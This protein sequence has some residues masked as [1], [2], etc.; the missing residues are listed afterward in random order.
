MTILRCVSEVTLLIVSVVP[1]ISRQ[2][3]TDPV[4]DKSVV[5]VTYLGPVHT[6]P[7][8]FVSANFFMR[9]HQASTRVRRIRSVYPEISVID[10]V[11]YALSK[12]VLKR[13]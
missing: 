2:R 13:N 9:I 3:T 10:G 12:G 11:Y 7:E 1:F 5:G 4:Y 8:I 6:Y